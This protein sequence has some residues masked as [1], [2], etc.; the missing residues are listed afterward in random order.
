MDS[1][2]AHFEAL[3]TRYRKVMDAMPGEGVR[4][5]EVKQ[6]GSKLYIRAVAPSDQAKNK[7]WDL[8]KA[9]NPSYSVDLVADI[10]V[11]APAGGAVAGPAS[12][13][14]GGPAGTASAGQK[15]YTVKAGD[16]LSKIAKEHY[17]ESSKYM[18]IFE[19]NKNILKDPDKI[20]P[21]QV[22]VIPPE[23]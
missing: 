3:K 5:E 14:P 19:A 10:K 20:Q 17:G 11:Q 9:A 22:L 8:I 13:G 18:Q 16:S 15:T 12:A 1:G 21:G 7:I 2:N 4:I 6:D 23:K